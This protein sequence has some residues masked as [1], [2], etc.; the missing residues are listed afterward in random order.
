[1]EVVIWTGLVGAGDVALELG[2]GGE[3]FADELGG[4]EELA[5][6]LGEVMAELEA[7]GGETGAELDGLGVLDAGGA[8]DFSVTVDLIGEEAG[9]ELAPPPLPEHL[10]PEDRVTST[11]FFWPATGVV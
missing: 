2:G 11:Q 5:G 8:V 10:P 1:V 4:A 7:G 3:G 9:E 6:G